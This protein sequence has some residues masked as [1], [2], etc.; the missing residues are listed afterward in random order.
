M[1]DLPDSI[2][3]DNEAPQIVAPDSPLPDQAASGARAGIL[4]LTAFALGRHWIAGDVATIITTMVGI[5]A[6][7]VLSQ[8]KTRHRATQLGNIGRDKRV[9]DSVV[10]T[11]AKGV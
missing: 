6:P 7:I 4:A 10:T 8:L 3:G 1:S 2:T 5:V 11:D 9:P